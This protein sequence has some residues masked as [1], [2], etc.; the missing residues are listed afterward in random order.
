MPYGLL[1]VSARVAATIF[2][3]KIPAII[4]LRADRKADC[5]DSFDIQDHLRAEQLHSEYLHSVFPAAVA[6]ICRKN[7]K[8]DGKIFPPEKMGE[9]ERK[10]ND[11]RGIYIGK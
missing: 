8:T 7:A 10:W 5:E 11:E 3:L 9:K 2:L 4:R 1:H 6:S